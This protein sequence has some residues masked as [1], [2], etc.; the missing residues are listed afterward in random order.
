MKA[1]ALILISAIVIFSILS[2][3]I[4]D[5]AVLDKMCQE[6]GGTRNGDTCMIPIAVE[7]SRDEYELE[8]GPV[9]IDTMEPNSA[10]LFHYPSQP[11]DADTYKLFVLIRLPEW[12]GGDADDASAFRAYSAK[13]LDDSCIVKYWPDKGR[14]RMENPCQGSMYRT[15]DG[16]MTYGAIY[17]S[18]AMTALPHLNLSSDANGMLYV[19]PPDFSKYQNG[20]I[21]YGKVMSM[22]E[23]RQGSK[24]LIE[25]FERHY[26][27]YHEIPMELG[28]YLLS[29]IYPGKHHTS[30][31]Y[32]NFQ[33]K[34]GQIEMTVKK[35]ASK[36]T[37]SDYDKSNV[38]YWQIGDSM[39][40]VGGSA[41][42]EQDETVKRF[43][44]YDVDFSKGHSYRVT[45]NDLEQ[46]KRAVVASFFPDYEYHELFLTSGKTRQ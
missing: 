7:S 13:S 17:R 4:I 34:S 16:A 35:I 20:V 30:V 26:P 44:T 23:I 32:L 11:K 22:E 46:I 21:G 10:R 38:E 9:Q 1:N 27:D 33:G 14:Q 2:V 36:I 42:N 45:G 39:I 43:R 6:K 40:R 31:K 29:E 24:M 19:N 41:M 37:R 28:G 12:M 18:T 5:S 8:P 15:I 25:S 3:I